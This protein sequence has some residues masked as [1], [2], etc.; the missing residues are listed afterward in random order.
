M[1][2]GRSSLVTALDVGTTKVCCFIARADGDGGLRVIGIGHQASRGMRAGT[3]IDMEAVEDSVRLAVDSA[4]R[5]AGETVRDV[6]VSIAS[7]RPQSDFIGVE[8]AV[9]GHEIGDAD[10]RRVLEQGRPRE[11]PE[12]R[13]ILHTLPTGFTIDGI[14]GV[15][16][17]RGMFGAQLGVN[18]HVVTVGAGPLHNLT[19]CVERGDLTVAETAVAPYA[20]GLST[21][22]EDEMRLGVTVVDLGGGTTTIGVFRDG[23]L[24]YADAVALGG[25]HVTND[26]AQGLATPTVYAERIKTLFG[27]AVASP[28]DERELIDVPQVGEGGAEDA[29]QVPRALLVSIIRPR[30]EEILELVRGRLDAARMGRAAGRRVVLTGGASQLQGLRQLAARILD[31]QV[32]MGRPLRIDG[33]AEA[34]SG[35]AFAACAGLLRLATREGLP[36]IADLAAIQA[37]GGGRVA[38]VGRWLRSNF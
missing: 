6:H 35:P 11:Q 5:M 34:T 16:D 25:L 13:S 10:L 28:A 15:R 1:A 36:A 21:L 8:V 38:R 33:L 37:G 3:V 32:R 27:S 14:N 29:N 19:L 23:D 18:I 9:D 20:S 12:D 4:E 31:K 26:I 2:V 24:A 7:G 30:V 17:P 22:V